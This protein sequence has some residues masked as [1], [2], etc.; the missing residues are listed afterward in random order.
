LTKDVIKI[1]RR[2]YEL[3]NDIRYEDKE[4]SNKEKLIEGKESKICWSTFFGRFTK[5]LFFIQF[6][7]FLLALWTLALYA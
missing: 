1:R 6:A 2:I 3:D 7:L 5:F 4:Q